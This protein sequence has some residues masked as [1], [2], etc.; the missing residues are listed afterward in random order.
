MLHRTNPPEVSTCAVLLFS[1][2]LRQ[3]AIKA[4]HE[5][6]HAGQQQTI[7]MA[8]NRYIWQGMGRAIKK[9]VKSCPVC[10]QVKINK[11][12]S[13]LSE[14]TRSTLTVLGHNQNRPATNTS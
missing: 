10:Q 9:L 14:K 1:P 3:A 5:D 2:A 4:L 6:T 12:G 8:R 13:F 7:K 11:Q